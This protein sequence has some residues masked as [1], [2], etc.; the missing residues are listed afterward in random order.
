MKKFII[1]KNVAYFV[2][3]FIAVSVMIALTVG[4][5]G[6]IGG[7]EFRSTLAAAQVNPVTIVISFLASLFQVIWIN[8][9]DSQ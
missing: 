6:A 1:V 5:L 7:Y 2:G 8:N 3:T 9:E 4:V